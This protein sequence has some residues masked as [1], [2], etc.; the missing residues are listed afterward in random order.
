MLLSTNLYVFITKSP[1]HESLRPSCVLS[2]YRLPEIRL[3]GGG[4][5]DLASVRNRRTASSKSACWK[6][7]SQT[8]CLRM[9]KRKDAVLKISVN[10]LEAVQGKSRIPGFVFLFQC[11]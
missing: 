2:G 11:Y 7:P 4:A 8:S 5:A 9:V 1:L 3:A 10:E 6:I